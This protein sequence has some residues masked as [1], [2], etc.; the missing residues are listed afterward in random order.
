V[1]GYRDA[2]VAR[3]QVVERKFA[4][5]LPTLRRLTGSGVIASHALPNYLLFEA[6]RGGSSGA[7]GNEAALKRS[8]A[9]AE[10]TWEPFDSAAAYYGGR[11]QKANVAEVGRTALTKFSEAPSAYPR[12]VSLY[13]RYG[14]TDDAAK[15]V[16]ECRRKQ[17]QMRLACEKALKK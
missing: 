6:Q 3:N 14:M 10:P 1:D 17:A 4:Q 7:A 13:V 11:N 16:A 12:L 8:L 15:V 5:A 9:A 2:F